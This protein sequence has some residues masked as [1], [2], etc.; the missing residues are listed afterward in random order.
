MGSLHLVV[1]AQTRWLETRCSSSLT[2]V[3]LVLFLCQ[4]EGRSSL[5]FGSLSI[6]V[7]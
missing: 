7:L 4:D 6:L 1:F 2:Y 3:D 5:V